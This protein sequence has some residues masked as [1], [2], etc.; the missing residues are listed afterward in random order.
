MAVDF[1]DYWRSLGVVTRVV[2]CLKTAVLLTTALKVIKPY[3][4]V[5][6][7]YEVVYNWQVWRLLTGAFYE[8]P[9]IMS[10][11]IFIMFVRWV[12][13]LE[14]TYG[15]RTHDAAFMLFFIIVSY[16]LWTYIVPLQLVSTWYLQLF[17]YYQLSRLMP[18]MIANLFVFNVKMEYFVWIMATIFLIDRGMA[19]WFLIPTSIG[20]SH[21][22]YFL[23]HMYPEMS[24]TNWMSAPGWFVTAFDWSLSLFGSNAVVRD[25][26]AQGTPL[27][28]IHRPAGRD[29]E[30]SGGVHIINSNAGANRSASQPR[31]SGRTQHNWGP[32]NSL[33]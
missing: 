4:L 27:R 12:H 24:G 18:G 22:Y 32:G 8:Q 6:D 28:V 5:M 15:H 33:Q 16:D 19:F 25:R 26:T 9:L 23:Y 2:A 13:I 3:Y 30:V 17:V 14:E 31:N 29:A 11:I 20:T 21:L 1:H 10:I 7:W